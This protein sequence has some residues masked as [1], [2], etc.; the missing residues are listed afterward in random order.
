[1]IAAEHVRAF[2]FGLTF[3]LAAACS[4]HEPPGASRRAAPQL[5]GSSTPSASTSAR[6]GGAAGT[7]DAV[8]TIA[9]DL[10]F[11]PTGT[12]LAS[13]AW[14]TWVYTD[15]GPNRERYGYLRAGSI[16]DAREPAIV[17]EGC[18]GG[19]HRINPRGFV[20]IGMGASRDLSHPVVVASSVRPTRGAGLPYIY[21]VAGDVAPL[22]YFRLPS[23]ADMRESEGPELEGR[24]ATYRE[25]L[26]REKLTDLLGPLGPPP[27]FLSSTRSL[28]K[29][30]GTVQGLRYAAHMGRAAPKSGFALSRAFEW[31]GRL[32]GLT[33]ELD[34]VG[35]ERTRLVRPSELRGVRFEGTQSLPVAFVTARFSMRYSRNAAGEFKPDGSFG[36]REALRLTGRG[37]PGSMAEI[38]GGA[39]AV[40]TT[41]RRVEPRTSFPS[42]VT[43]DRKWIDVSI[44]EQTLVA[45]E[46][47]RPV[48]A[49]LVSTGI[50]GLGDPETSHATVRG[51]FMIYQK[52]VS[53]T[54][55]GEGAEAADSYALRDVPFVQYFHEGYALHGTY[56]HDEFGKW[57]SHGCVNLSP[58]DAAWLFEWTDPAVPADW[59]GVVNKER[60]TVVHIHP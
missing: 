45:Y 28:E 16:A 15:T 57:R 22:L 40:E 41:L 2:V 37:L 44:N 21:A 6:A 35:L 48:F 58:A 38:E 42:L 60:G 39:W 46:G 56:W 3:G 5:V 1:M 52:E 59:H 17:N 11:S 7:M 33:T 30:Y 29:P 32:F 49:T 23:A 50:G 27:P 51:T 20:C 54:M 26:A 47:R 34:V 24:V 12:R 55:D 4:R 8:G 10:P 13:I 19:W 53:S 18:R 9:D 36:Y 14:R 43:G 25:R 31:E